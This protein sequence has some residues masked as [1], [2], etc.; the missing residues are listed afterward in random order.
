RNIRSRFSA[1]SRGC[2]AGPSQARV[3]DSLSA[4]A[5]SSA[6]RARFGSNRRRTR[7][8]RFISRCQRRRGKGPPHMSDPVRILLVEDNTGDIYLFRKALTATALN[9][10]MTVIQDGGAGMEFVRGEGEFAGSQVPD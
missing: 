9:F 7:E 4:N 8:P 6:T 5:L 2:T 10:E 3:L 1:C